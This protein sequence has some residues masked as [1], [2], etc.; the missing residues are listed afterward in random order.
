VKLLLDNGADG[1][2]KDIMYGLTPLSWL[3]GMIAEQ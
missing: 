3:P 1:E 2:S